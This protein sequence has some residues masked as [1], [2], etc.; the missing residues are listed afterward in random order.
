MALR[1][2]QLYDTPIHQVILLQNGTKGLAVQ[3]T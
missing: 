3:D 2:P 1:H